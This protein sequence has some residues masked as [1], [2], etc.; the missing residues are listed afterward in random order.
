MSVWAKFT[1]ISSCKH[2]YLYS[3]RWQHF[4]I[5]CL[6]WWEKMGILARSLPGNLTIW[7]EILTF[8]IKKYIRNGEKSDYHAGKTT[9]FQAMIV[10]LCS[11]VV[12]AFKFSCLKVNSYAFCPYLMKEL[13]KELLKLKKKVLNKIQQYNRGQHYSSDTLELISDYVFCFNAFKIYHSHLMSSGMNIILVFS[14]FP[15]VWFTP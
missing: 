15:H 1:K 7:R 14:R 13:Y 3:K 9:L 2:F 5:W 8:E 6:P 4:Q 10:C 12:Q 11:F